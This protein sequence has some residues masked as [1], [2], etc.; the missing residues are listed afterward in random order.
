VVREPGDRT[1]IAVSSRDSAVDPV[2]AC[3]GVKGS[4]V[5]AVVRELRGEKVDI[6]AW[7]DDIRTFIGEALSPAAIEKV[8]INDEEKSALVVVGDQQLSLAIGK[9][10]QNV[11]LAAKLTGWKIDIM[12]ESEYDKARSKE[13][14]KEIS[15]AIAQTQKEQQARE[16]KGVQKEVRAEAGV[17]KP[18][19]IEDL[20]GIGKKTA[21]ALRKHGFD[22]IIKIAGASVEALLEVPMIGQKTAQKLIPLAKEMV[23][24]A[25]A[26]MASEEP[27]QAGQDEVAEIQEGQPDEQQVEGAIAD[28]GPEETLVTEKENEEDA[29]EGTEVKDQGRGE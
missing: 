6:I 8:G 17:L 19:S 12:S 5:Q 14:E 29:G 24:S 10:G 16:Y 1:K 2:G 11:R 27:V 13:R 15:D 18:L 4:R 7:T 26:E 22:T 25:E 28:G 3:V 21:E 9:K 20:P 23:Q